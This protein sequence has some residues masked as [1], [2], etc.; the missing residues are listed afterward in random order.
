[1]FISKGNTKIFSTAFGSKANPVILAIGGWVGS[2][3]LWAEPFSI[4]SQDWYTIAYDHRG[5]GAT[6]TPVET[7]TY[8]NL[9]EDVFTVLDAYQ[10]DRCVL[11]AES[12]GALTA[13]GAARKQ[14]DRISGLVIVDGLFY[15]SSSE[16]DPFLAGLRENYEATI[17]QFIEACVPE[18]DSDHLK[19]WGKK[20]INRASQQ[21]AIALYLSNGQ[22]DLRP[23]LPL[24]SQ[25]T[26]ILHG[27]ADTIVPVTAAQHLAQTLPHA[28]LVLLKGAGHVPTMTQPAKIAEKIADFF[29]IGI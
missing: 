11:A 13:L 20:I 14:P 23:E 4:L 18:A 26:L 9:V 17:D 5:T 15:F 22:V 7:I 27:E 28:K 2:W 12:A 19:G 8:D 24:L 10:V 29:M 16:G 6:I 3:E 21:A 1:M 25:P